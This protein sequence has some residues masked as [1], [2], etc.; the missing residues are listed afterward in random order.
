MVP[1]KYIPSEIKRPKTKPAAEDHSLRQNR[2]ECTRREEENWE[3]EISK[4]PTCQFHLINAVTL[5]RKC[6]ISCGRSYPTHWPS[7]WVGGLKV[8][9][10]DVILRDSEDRV[11]L[12]NGEGTLWRDCYRWYFMVGFSRTRGCTPAWTDAGQ[13][14]VFGVWLSE[15]SQWRWRSG[16][17]I[18][19]YPLCALHTEVGRVAP[20]H[21]R[22]SP[23]WLSPAPQEQ[24]SILAL[25]FQSPSSGLVC[26]P[27]RLFSLLK[28]R[29]AQKHSTTY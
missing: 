4:S 2:I 20:F 25:T 28:E 19:C 8:K 7:S 22:S 26:P 13:H 3:M 15:D 6:L 12:G 29:E 1:V 17:N 21:C 14:K 23:C 24:P 11:R 18:L 16:R 5:L 27:E 9:G 10:E